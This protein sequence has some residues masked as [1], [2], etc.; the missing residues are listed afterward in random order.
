MRK[1]TLL[2][3]ALLLTT[4][5]AWAQTVELKASTSTEKPEHMYLLVNGWNVLMDKGT[6]DVRDSEAPGRFAFFAVEG[7]DDTYKIMSVDADQNKWLS[8]PET[9]SN[10]TKVSLVASQDDAKE[11][12]ITSSNIL[13]TTSGYIFQPYSTNG[14]VAGQY[15]NW[16][17]GVATAKDAV[18]FH[19]GSATGD[20]G[21]GWKLVIAPTSGRKYYLQ[22][23][24]DV[25]VSLD[26]V[27]SSTASSTNATL[28]STPKAFKI[29]VTEDGEWKISNESNAYLGANKWDAEVGASQSDFSWTVEVRNDGKLGSASSEVYYVLKQAKDKNTSGNYLNWRGYLGCDEHSAGNIL[30]CNQ[31]NSGTNSG[32]YSLNEKALRLRLIDGEVTYVDVTIKVKNESDTKVQY[33]T[34]VPRLKVG[35][36]IT[37]SDYLPTFSFISYNNVSEPVTVDAGTTEY[38][39]TYSVDTEA[40]TKVPFATSYEDLISKNKWVSFMTWN[41]RMYVYDEN[42]VGNVYSGSS[43]TPTSTI[44]KYPCID[45]AT[46]TRLNGDFF[47]GFIRADRF[48]PVYIVNKGAE[49]VEENGYNATDATKY[50]YLT[51]NGNDQPLL[52]EAKEGNSTTAGWTTKEWV[53]EKGKISGGTQYFGIRAN[54]T[55]LYINNN[56]GKGFMTTLNE[57]TTKDN[58]SNIKFTDELITY[59]I[60][61]DRALKAP[62]NAVHSLNVEAR[63]AVREISDES[64]AAYKAVIDNINA[65]GN[66]TGYIQFDENKYYYLR[67]YTPETADAPVYVLGSENGTAAC[68][69]TVTEGAGDADNAM[70]YSNINAIWKITP[71]GDG[72][73]P[74]TGG[75]TGASRALPRRLTH[76]NSSKQLTAV[77]ADA[78][79]RLKL[80]ESGA[81]YYFIDLGA[82]QH[83]MKNVAYKGNG[84][85][86]KSP[87]ISC[88]NGTLGQSAAAHYKNSR[89]AWY[90]IPV[91]S[92][93]VTITD[94]GYATIYL[95]FGVTLP[96]GESANKLEAYAVTA[97]G[98]GVATLTKVESIPANEGVILKGTAGTTYTLT[99]DDTVNAWEEGY[100]KLSG[101]NLHEN[102]DAEAYVLSKQNNVVGLYKADKS[103][104][105]WLNNDNKA[106]LLASAVT[107]AEAGARF[108]SFNF[109]T[110]TGLDVIKGTESASSESV[111]Y[112]LSGRRVRNAQKGLYIVNGKKVVK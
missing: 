48:S 38:V 65:V 94:A 9:P 41:G 62:F 85:Q 71:N 64:V 104:G 27:N 8:Y 75:Y 35:E 34:T 70:T 52:F 68:A 28:V 93:K 67:N 82:G 14:S 80:V 101:S 25:F 12:K 91:S 111:V 31:G 20:R 33:E 53:I 19:T 84:D 78:N 74:S 51:S 86:S 32:T 26:D 112:D 59:N 5:G 22:D 69:F 42:S 63:S 58:G 99:I 39:V 83:F 56:A 13:G 24:H 72:Q 100:N 54:G 103:S 23:K 73:Q 81:D 10:S 60:M 50:L 6:G 47:W 21:S 105:T 36:S 97:A 89:D 44:T 76:I 16:Y 49:G 46:F 40:E 88:N 98:D 11:W 43:S 87:T 3:F 110:V 15:M 95:P 108:L 102:I 18:L 90:G 61:K 79:N 7:K 107:D 37:L 77:T 45:K 66:E 1:I 4:V 57:N 2:L 106:Y 55:N 109:D 96:T 30:F 29:D 92:I 17:G